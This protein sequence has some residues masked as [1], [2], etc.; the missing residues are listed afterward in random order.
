MARVATT[1]EKD[2]QKVFSEDK[3]H[4]KSDTYSLKAYMKEIGDFQ[5]STL[6][7]RQL[8]QLEDLQV[9]TITFGDGKTGSVYQGQI[10]DGFASGIGRSASA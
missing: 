3:I 5:V 8:L 9:G 4:L 7:N 1:Y 10:K 6:I 2:L